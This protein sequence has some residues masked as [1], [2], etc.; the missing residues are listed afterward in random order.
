MQVNENESWELLDRSLI[1][2]EFPEGLLG[3]G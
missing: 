2:V 1:Q 3:E